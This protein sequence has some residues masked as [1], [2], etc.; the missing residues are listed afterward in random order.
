M[1]LDRRL[2]R[3]QRPQPAG[4][5]ALAG[6]LLLDALIGEPPAAAHPV[7]WM[8]WLLGWLERRA[9]RSDPARFAYGLAAAVGLPLLWGALGWAAERRIPWPLQALTLKPAFA[10]RALLQ[11]G[12]AVEAAL[13]RQ[14]LAAARAGLRALV[15]RPTADLGEDLVAAAAVESLAE[16]VTDSWVAPLLAYALGGL[17][18]AYAYRAANTADAMWGYHSADCEWLGKA[19]ARLDDALSWLPARLAALALVAA[20]DDRT[21][22]IRG[23]RRDAGRTGSPNA[24]QTM[25]AMAGALN[26]RLEKRGA[27]VLNAAARC[28]TAGDIAEARRLVRRAMVLSAMLA[29]VLTDLG[30]R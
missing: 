11:A 2:P 17:G 7:V 16:N 8:G 13:D 24:G 6:A 21:R 30:D 15:S 14:D 27:Y 3:L 9:P 20:A 19:A 25:A 23:W 29:L 22:A 1:V 28:P 18:T 12:R 26:V 10:G 5:A 4:A